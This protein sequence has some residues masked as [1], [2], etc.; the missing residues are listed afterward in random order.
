[1]KQGNQFY[2]EIQIEDTD[3]ANL[4]IK[5]VDKVQFVI[6]DLVKL[7]DGTNKEVSYDEDKKCFKIWL[8]ED[9]TFDFDRNIKI[10]VRVLYKANVEGKRTIDGSVICSCYCYDSL[11]KIELDNN[12]PEPIVKVIVKNGTYSAVD[13]NVGYYD[14]VVVNVPEKKLGT[15][16][17][18]QSGV[19]TVKYSATDDNLD[20]YSE[21][22][23]STSGASSYKIEKQIY[24]PV[25]NETEH[26]FS[27]NLGVVPDLI[28]IFPAY[29]TSSNGLNFVFGKRN[30]IFNLDEQSNYINAFYGTNS[31]GS[32]EHNSITDMNNMPIKQANEKSFNLYSQTSNLFYL[33]SGITY[34]IIIMA[35]VDE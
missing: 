13:D 33:K 34:Y 15:K 22:N 6:K 26:T 11:K 12:L 8:T 10:D 32:C 2:L 21:V 1:M 28:I 16:N 20:G 18:V 35:G 30:N 19:K 31:Y 25:E 24:T 14:K 27:H 17:I 4:D 9:E 29:K 5:G 7:Y 23:V 3:G